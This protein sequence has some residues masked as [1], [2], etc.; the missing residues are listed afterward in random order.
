MVTIFLIVGFKSDY[1]FILSKKEEKEIT[2]F[3]VKSKKF[4]SIS[5]IFIKTFSLG[6]QA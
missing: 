2:E 5:Q 4:H 3:D 1:L 6:S